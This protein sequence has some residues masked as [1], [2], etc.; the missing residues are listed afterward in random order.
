M[1]GEKFTTVR[2]ALEATVKRAGL[3]KVTWHMCR[4]TFA[5]RLV[6]EDAKRRAVKKLDGD[7][8]ATIVQMPKKIAV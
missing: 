2:K 3:P 5:T 7:K 6:N 8:T 4:H 1:S